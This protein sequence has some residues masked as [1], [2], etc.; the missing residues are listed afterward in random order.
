M[1]L[2][3]ELNIVLHLTKVSLLF[4]NFPEGT[5]TKIEN[6]VERGSH[7]L[8]IVPKTHFKHMLYSQKTFR[9]PL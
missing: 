1:N 3:L 2:I 7:Y 8:N 6:L 4:L 5:N 9:K